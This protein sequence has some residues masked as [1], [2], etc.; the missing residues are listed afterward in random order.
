MSVTGRGNGKIILFNEHF[1]VYGVP[2]IASS[3]D[4]YVEAE[5]ADSD[6]VTIFDERINRTNDPLEKRILEVMSSKMNID[7]NKN[8]IK[9]IIRGDIPLGSGLGASAATCVAIARALSKY[10]KL[11]LSDEEI[12]SIAYEGE[13]IYHGNPSGID[14]TVATFGGVIWF[15]RGKKAERINIGKPLHIIIGN[16]G[17]RASTKKAIEKVR[18]NREKD[19]ERFENLLNEVKHLAQSARKYIEE[20]ELKGIGELMNKNHELLQEIGVSCK[21]LD[22]LVD[23]F[24][25]KGALGA[26]LTGGG[27]GGNAIALVEDADKQDV[28]ADE[29]EREGFDVIK[30]RV[31]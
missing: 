23:L 11:D 2:A 24:L 4:R 18:R 3:I 30:V 28:I 5:I 17:V 20:G 12:N 16:T 13:R 25:R 26:K 10:F 14:N 29:I 21:K 31:E 15:E 19:P 27:L 6:T 22:Y 1:V 9:V 8:P 7:L